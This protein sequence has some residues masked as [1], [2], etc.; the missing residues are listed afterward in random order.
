MEGTGGLRLGRAC[1]V[2]LRGP[3]STACSRFPIP[4]RNPLVFLEFPAASRTCAQRHWQYL[5]RG[6][7]DRGNNEG[8]SS[9]KC[10]R[11]SHWQAATG[12]RGLPTPMTSR[13]IQGGARANSTEEPQAKPQE[14]PCQAKPGD[15]RSCASRATH[16]AGCTPRAPAAGEAG[17]PEPDHGG[18]SLP[19]SPCRAHP[20]S[21]LG[22]C[23]SSRSS[24]TAVCC[25]RALC[26][27]SR[28]QGP[29]GRRQAGHRAP[30]H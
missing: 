26:G 23:C 18:C 1:G 6:R 13:E 24:Q 25:G 12:G 19:P 17:R 7:T 20:H 15:L 8:P 28:A 27:E 16:Q 5:R 3:P 2:L 14:V 11:G 30:A 29:W 10:F 21:P 4:P 22:P 9:G